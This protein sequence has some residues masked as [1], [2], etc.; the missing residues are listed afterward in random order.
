M[1][2][3]Y[4]APRESQVHLWMHRDGCST[5]GDGDERPDTLYKGKTNKEIE[6]RLHIQIACDGLEIS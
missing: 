6:V 1:S 4:D 3:G 2:D 5:Y